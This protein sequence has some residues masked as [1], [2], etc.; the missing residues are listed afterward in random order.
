MKA[1]VTLK[2]GFRYYR[3]DN[4]FVDLKEGDLFETDELS[5]FDQA[6]RLAD[7]HYAPV[8]EATPTLPT[9]PPAPTAE[10]SFKRSKK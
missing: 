7:G 3:R 8:A 5:L 6:E 1:K 10:P 2:G 4:S 9:P